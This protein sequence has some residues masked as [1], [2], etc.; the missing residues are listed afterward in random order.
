M[1]GTMEFYKIVSNNLNEK[2]QKTILLPVLYRRLYWS[3]K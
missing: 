3:F 1:G 2:I